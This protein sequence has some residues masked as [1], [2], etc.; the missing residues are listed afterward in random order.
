MAHGPTRHLPSCSS[1]QEHG[2]HACLSPTAPPTHLHF[3]SSECSSPLRL[4]P[5]T[6]RR[7]RP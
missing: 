5:F 3:P 7:H 6:V 1:S 2:R 4:Q